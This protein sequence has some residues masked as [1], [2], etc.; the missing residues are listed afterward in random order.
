LTSFQA[1]NVDL[2]KADLEAR[3]VQVEPLAIDAGLDQGDAEEAGN[4]DVTLA[5]ATDE[6]KE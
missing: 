3:G 4:V 5:A 1:F 6:E 2:I